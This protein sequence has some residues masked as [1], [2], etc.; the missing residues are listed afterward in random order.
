MLGRTKSHFFAT[1]ELQREWLKF[2]L[3]MEEKWVYNKAKNGTTKDRNIIEKKI[4]R[5]MLKLENVFDKI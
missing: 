2:F 4:T 1:K 5:G 3:L